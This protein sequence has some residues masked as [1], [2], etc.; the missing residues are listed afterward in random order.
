M[1]AYPVISIMFVIHESSSGRMLAES[2]GNCKPRR[3]SAN[4]EYVVDVHCVISGTV[5][6]FSQKGMTND[7]LLEV[8]F[9]YGVRLI[10]VLKT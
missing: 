4:D 8:G 9:N 6:L 1:L 10:E 5:F 3:S 2:G 7:A